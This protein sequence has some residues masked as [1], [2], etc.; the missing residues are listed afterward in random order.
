MSRSKLPRHLLALVNEVLMRG[1]AIALYNEEV[2][3]R[4]EI[5]QCFQ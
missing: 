1:D 2:L 5:Q 3:D 4:P